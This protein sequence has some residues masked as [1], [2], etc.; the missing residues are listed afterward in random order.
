MIDS[1][2]VVK[3]IIEKLISYTITETNRIQN[4]KVIPSV[5]Y[6][7]MKTLLL[8]TVQMELITYDQDLTEKTT[9]EHEDQLI[10]EIPSRQMFYGNRISGIN[11]YSF[12]EIP[13]YFEL[14]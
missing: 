12:L 10:E 9:Y 5:C 3:F 1:E 4:S 13:V 7:Y 11:D 14:P 6:D 8:E 2:I